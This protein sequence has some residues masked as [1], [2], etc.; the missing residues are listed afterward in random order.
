MPKRNLLAV[1]ALH[2]GQKFVDLIV[3]SWVVF[4]VSIQ[5][6]GWEIVKIPKV[7]MYLFDFPLY[8]EV[9]LVLD[10]GMITSLEYVWFQAAVGHS[11][12][13]SEPLVST[14][15]VDG[16]DEYN[17]RVSLVCIRKLL[18]WA[19]CGRPYIVLLGECHTLSI[20]TL[21]DKVPSFL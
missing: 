16:E 15:F 5:W 10:L 12:H 11:F 7:I 2:D 9:V 20:L 18:R 4:H 3:A 21:H 8:W 13:D 17:I 14:T 19:K 6:V 1:L